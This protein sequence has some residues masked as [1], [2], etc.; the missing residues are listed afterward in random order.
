MADNSTDSIK[1]NIKRIFDRK[2]NAIIALCFFYGSLALRYFQS[3]QVGNRFW[4]NQTRT[5]LRT[6]FSGVIETK[7]VVG[8]FLAHT[9]DYGVYLELANDRQNESLRPSVFRFY[10]RFVRDLEKIL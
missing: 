10:S 8:F 5:A 7:N 4:N 3:Q 6:V 9:V 2:R 1:R